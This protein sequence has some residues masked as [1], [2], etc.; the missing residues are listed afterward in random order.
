V[1][2]EEI[3]KWIVRNQSVRAEI[4]SLVSNIDSFIGL[5]MAQRFSFNKEES[6]KFH[7]IFFDA[8]R[9]TFHAK[10]EI[11]KRFLR[12]YEPELLENQCSELPAL[13]KEVKEVRNIFAHSWDPMVIELQQKNFQDMPFAKVYRFQNGQGN[14]WT[15][16]KTWEMDFIPN[17]KIDDGISALG[18]DRNH[19]TFSIY[20]DGQEL[21]AKQIL[22]EI[23]PKCGIEPFEE[24]GDVKFYRYPDTIYK[25]NDP[26]V[27]KM[28]DHENEKAMK[29]LQKMYDEMY[30]HDYKRI[31][32]FQSD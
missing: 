18:Y 4:L 3:T 21:L 7:G 17:G 27:Q 24:I 31:E 15:F 23:C 16:D 19:K 2:D 13:L 29:T 28:L 30:N 10:I 8:S 6:R 12:E 5:Q 26:I 22:A 20:K 11:Y 32:P 14:T 1:N 25:L 9:V